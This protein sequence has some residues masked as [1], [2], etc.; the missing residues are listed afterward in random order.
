MLV[1]D[2]VALLKNIASSINNDAFD[3]EMLATLEKDLMHFEDLSQDIQKRF[4]KDVNNLAETFEVIKPV[5]EF[6]ALLE[7]RKKD[8]LKEF[9]TTVSK[10]FDRDVSTSMILK[11]IN[12]TL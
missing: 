7:S 12:K 10:E 5:E 8:Y 11:D 4:M 6:K 1:D 3:R 9:E 2:F